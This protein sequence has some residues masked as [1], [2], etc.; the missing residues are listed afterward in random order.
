METVTLLASDLGLEH[1]LPILSKL[2]VHGVRLRE[3]DLHCC[4]SGLNY[5]VVDFCAMY[6]ISITFFTDTLTPLW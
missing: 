1:H 2:G 6:L 3:R 4:I 5:V